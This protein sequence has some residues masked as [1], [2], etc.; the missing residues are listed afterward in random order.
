MFDLSSSDI[1]RQLGDR[2]YARGKGYARAGH[3][4]DIKSDVTEDGLWIVSQVEGGRVYA[5]EIHLRRHA[6]GLEIDGEC[7]CPVGY[8]C[9]HVAAVL[10]LLTMASEQP[11]RLDAVEQ[12]LS[13]LVHDDAAPLRPGDDVLL[14]RLAPDPNDDTAL[15]LELHRARVRK[16]GTGYGKSRTLS[17]YDI[18]G[19]QYNRLSRPVDREVLPLIETMMGYQYRQLQ[20]RDAAGA[21]VLSKAARSGRL[22]WLDMGSPALAWSQARSLVAA[23][24]K[25]EGK[26]RLHLDTEPPGGRPLALD[27]PLYF[28]QA[29]GLVGPLQLDAGLDRR[30]LA[31]LL[32]APPIPMD[33][34]RRLSVQLVQRF[35]QLPL[36][37]PAEITE[38]AVR[39]PALPVVSLGGL[40]AGPANPDRP[41]VHTAVLT[42]A[43]GAHRLAPSADAQARLADDSRLYRI[44]RDP[45]VERAAEARLI[46]AG[47]CNLGFDDAAVF[48][49]PAET[50]L[51]SVRRW[52]T[53]VQDIVPALEHEGWRIERDG[54]FAL[55]FVQAQAIEASIDDQGDWFGLQ[56]GIDVDGHRV[57][58]APLLA[59]LLGRI[60]SPESLP[61]DEMLLLEL[62]DSRWL[63][64]PSARVKPLLNTLFQLFDRASDNS[65]EGLRLSRMDAA[66][67]DALDGVVDRWQG[68]DAVRALG[69]RLAE[70][71][72]IAPV[73]PPAGLKATLRDYQRRGLDWLQ[74]LRE[75][76]FG[77]ILADD[78]GL[79]KTV[80][81]LA[82]LLVEKAAGRLTAPA[83]I[84]AP[85]SLMANWRHEAKR[86]APALSV[87]TL[88]GP[89]RRQHF[90]D[91]T[92]HDLVL[93]TYPLLPRDE[94]ALKAHDYHALILDEAQTIKNP[95]AK[96]A[97]VA[98][99]LRAN[100][101]LCLTGTPMENH[102]GELWSLFHFLAPGYLGDDRQFKRLFR[103]P[104]ERDGDLHRRERL[105]RRIAP[106]LLRRTKQ[107][108]A[109][110][111]PE[112]TVITRTVGFEREQA[113]LYEGVRAAMDKKISD[114]LANK[115]LARSHITILDALLKL[116]QICCDPRLVK[117]E[118]AKKVA[119]SAKLELLLQMLP[120]LLDEGRRVLLFSQFTSMLKLI[121]HEL[122]VLGIG[123][124]KLTGQT[125]KREQAIER[126]RSGEVPLFL[127]SLKAGGVGL[128]L[129]E[130][131]TV[132]HYDPWWNP[133][134][135]NQATD[136][137]H[138]IGQTNKVFVYKL[139]TEDTVEEKILALQA[140]K[141]ALAEGVYGRAAGDGLQFNEDDLR[142]LLRPLDA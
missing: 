24:H 50:P 142:E 30:Q 36:P 52:R 12:W 54:S 76:G 34:A 99:A 17:R 38:V 108:V 33:A 6:R 20:L 127:I 123:Y 125:R 29:Q 82:H 69:A 89:Q 141:A 53:F 49:M 40:S 9:K 78:M 81:T 126:F 113:E 92:R 41:V 55:D 139:V 62:D 73:E 124:S 115:G 138:R 137:A 135:E 118:Q 11:A 57:D 88:Q 107:E 106:F 70:L 116:R 3:V 96:A 46:D 105:Q 112:K 14:Y 37:L 72:A 23:W 74:F 4:L 2:F 84:V 25:E 58:L 15:L 32:K 119:R 43:Y 80:Q 101:R 134:V 129:T 42:F 28:D 51:Q 19:L 5:Q 98:R 44:E 128:N 21:V 120:E 130:A 61:D 26:L 75:F 132:I 48:V 35:P 71:S 122:D 18:S 8:N 87:L 45:A 95:R 121:E 27:P 65:D 110:E 83:L 64:L 77:G 109:S 102:L 22:H 39:E 94:D 85:T 103:T 133:A 131:D 60:D 1:R 90:A 7:S 13:G 104:I 111:L 31:A 68:G 67:L 47:L 97:Q 16:N 56:L 86:F 100:H 59:D 117:L 63:E 114:A 93:T 66:Q 136:R 79:G 10:I 91:I 140:R